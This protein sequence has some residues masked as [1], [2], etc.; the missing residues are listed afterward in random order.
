MF[1]DILC[2]PLDEALNGIHNRRKPTLL[3]VE[4]FPLRFL[5]SKLLIKSLLTNE[6]E[7]IIVTP[8]FN[9]R[10]ARHETVGQNRV[11][12]FGKVLALFHAYQITEKLIHDSPCNGVFRADFFSQ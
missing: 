3:S 8:P 11:V 1:W 10:A 6:R 4:V 2:S 5:Q 12:V 9:K 7:I